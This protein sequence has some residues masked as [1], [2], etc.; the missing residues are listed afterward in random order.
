MVL[1]R[2]QNASGCVPTIPQAGQSKIKVKAIV[3]D[4]SPPGTVPR[5]RH[6][7]AIASEKQLHITYCLNDSQHTLTIRLQAHALTDE[8]AS[9]RKY[10]ADFF[11]DGSK[12]CCGDLI[13]FRIDRRNRAW[14]SELCSSSAKG[15]TAETFQTLYTT[16][17]KPRAFL[18]EYPLEQDEIMYID[19][20]ELRAPL[21]GLGLS[22]TVL[23]AVYKL[24]GALEGEYKFGGTV[25]LSPARPET[26]HA[27][28]H[29]NGVNEF[30]IE[31]VLMGLY[32]KAGYEVWVRGERNVHSVSVMGRT[33][34]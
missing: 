11:V 24:F 16:T 17:G 13:A 29:W 22:T 27:K 33:I 19:S 32:G 18:R 4:I 5:Q 30:D 2:G 3:T 15:A 10:V 28:R 25:V 23:E 26:E 14:V 9:A 20:F 1:T 8:Y 21:A 6:N 31:R 12:R 7:N 34:P